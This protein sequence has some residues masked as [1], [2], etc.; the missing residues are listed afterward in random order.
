MRR[1]LTALVPPLVL[2]LVVLGS[3]FAGVAT[4]TEAGALGA[5]GLTGYYVV[6]GLVERAKLAELDPPPSPVETNGAAAVEAA[7]PEETVPE[8]APVGSR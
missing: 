6:F 7:L 2:I 3:I 5:V 4:P 8:K 1:V